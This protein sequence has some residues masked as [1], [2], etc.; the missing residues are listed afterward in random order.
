[1][2]IVFA[3]E[4]LADCFGELKPLI[5]L[6]WREGCED[7]DDVRLDP[8]FD[9]YHRLDRT[10]LLVCVTA[11]VDGA[12]VGYLTAFLTPN[13][14]FRS[15]PRLMVGGYYILPEHRTG[16][17]LSRLMRYMETIARRLKVTVISVGTGASVD[18]GAIFERAKYVERDRIYSKILR[19]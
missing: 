9:M 7:Q 8:D 12:M 15:T 17:A 16:F 5:Y 10:G 1:M 11:R 2:T 14:N 6:H 19:Y 4:K 18:R 3:E 13:P